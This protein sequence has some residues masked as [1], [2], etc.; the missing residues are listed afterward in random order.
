MPEAKDPPADVRFL[1]SV[2]RDRHGMSGLTLTAHPVRVTDANEVR[3]ITGD[4]WRPDPLADFQVQ[5][6]AE[7]EGSFG[8]TYGWSREYR[9]VFS[10]VTE[11]AAVM[12]KHLRA[13]DRGMAKLE[14]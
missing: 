5:A 13:L 9:N 6:R 4:H 10:V 1:L 8:D 3:N 2:E 7:A 11:R 12:L 14:Q